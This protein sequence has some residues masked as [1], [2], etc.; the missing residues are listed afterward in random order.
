MSFNIRPVVFQKNWPSIYGFG[1]AERA[2]DRFTKEISKKESIAILTCGEYYRGKEAPKDYRL[3]TK[4]FSKKKV[5][6]H[7]IPSV[8]QI[9]DFVIKQQKEIGLFQIG[10]GFEHYPY[11]F[12]RILN[13]KLPLVFRVCEKNQYNQL[14]QELPK[15]E[16]SV[17][18]KK[19]IERVNALVA[20]SDSLVKEA[21]NYGF[22]RKRIHLIYSSVD[23]KI[24][25]P[26]N[27]KHKIIIRK[28]LGLRDK[29][30]TFL[31]IGRIAKDK[32]V[33]MLLKAWV[34]LPNSFK[35]QNQLVV[36]GASRK[37]DPI[38]D[39]FKSL[40]ATKPKSI[41][42]PG[43]ILDERKVA[44]YYQSSDIFIY[45]SVH[46]EGLSVSILEAMSSG[47]PV[48][49]TKWAATQTGVSDLVKIGKTGIVF[50]EE[51]G[52]RGLLK[53]LTNIDWNFIP[54]LGKAARNHVLTLGVDNKVASKKYI[55]LY[56]KL[57]YK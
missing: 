53:T 23:T 19:M 40:I 3:P 21:I 17:F 56:K 25:S 2:T 26:A 44:Q 16:K 35:D 41:I 28:K 43:V 34:S 49:T 42:F 18:I 9:V 7:E 24:F 8:P 32:G 27:A 6:I 11:D 30:K 12:N 4:I 48:V 36:V 52:S 57:L 5:T 54:S 14:T 33:D 29:K 45:P 47:L 13:I 22:D 50:N 1:G 37:N 31:F 39:Y 10:W 20:I 55:K 15:E 51:S 46:N 38:Y